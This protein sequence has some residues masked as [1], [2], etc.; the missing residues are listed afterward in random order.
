ML[1]YCVTLI[2][3]SLFFSPYFYSSMLKNME[4]I[5]DKND[6]ESEMTML[7]KRMKTM[8]SDFASKEQQL[9]NYNKECD[10]IAEQHKIIKSEQIKAEPATKKPKIVSIVKKSVFVGTPLDTKSALRARARASASA[11]TLSFTSPPSN[12]E[13]DSD[14]SESLEEQE[15]V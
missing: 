3:L 1:T 13:I 14:D 10:H 9:A 4:K 8:R 5:M 15:V 7:Y 12:L 6:F 2:A 11:T